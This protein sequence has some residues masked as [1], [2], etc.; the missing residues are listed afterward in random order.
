MVLGY[1]AIVSYNVWFSKA[2]IIGL[3]NGALQIC[4]TTPNCVSTSDTTNDSQ[5]YITPYNFT[6]ATALKSNISSIISSK[7]W[8]IKSSED[9]YWHIV[10]KTS[11]FRFRDDF[12]IFIN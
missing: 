9:N 12:E 1:I 4:P 5:H 10:V 2:A 3:K 11:F 8:E 7:K 6:N